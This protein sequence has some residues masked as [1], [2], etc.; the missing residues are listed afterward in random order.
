MD[1]EQAQDWARVLLGVGGLAAI[2]I[3]SSI[4]ETRGPNGVVRKARSLGVL[5]DL[6]LRYFRPRDR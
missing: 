4:E 6:I 5:A 2:I 1:I 3:G